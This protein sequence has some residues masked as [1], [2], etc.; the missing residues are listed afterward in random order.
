MLDHLFSPVFSP[1]IVTVPGSFYQ[2]Y[3]NRE[4]Q[5]LLQRRAGVVP[6]MCSTAGVSLL[7]TILGHNR[8]S[9]GCLE[10]PPRLLRPQYLVDLSLGEALPRE[11]GHRSPQLASNA[12]NQN[13]IDGPPL[14]PEVLDVDLARIGGPQ[15]RQFGTIIVGS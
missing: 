6:Y 11:D 5:T 4:I 15:A 13:P 9:G 3:R 1:Y 8:A 7:N 10:R 12:T 14:C 2:G